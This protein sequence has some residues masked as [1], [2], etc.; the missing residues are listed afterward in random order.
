MA[1]RGVRTLVDTT[2]AMELA[3]SWKP[4]MYSNT[5]ATRITVSR[6]VMGQ[7]VAQEFLSTI[8]TMM[9]PASR[10]RSMTFSKRS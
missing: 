2:V 1:S 4:L 3:V 7:W 8:C 9:F 5:R 6:R 10:Q